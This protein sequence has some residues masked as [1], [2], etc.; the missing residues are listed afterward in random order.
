[1][2]TSRASAIAL[3]LIGIAVTIVP[4]APAQDG[5]PSAPNPVGAVVWFDLLTEDDDAVLDFYREL[6]GWEIQAHTDRHWVV[7]HNGRPIAGISQIPNEDPKAKEAFW[8]AGI[9]VDDVDT[10]FQRASARGAELHVEPADS[11]G[12]ARYAII[13][14]NDG[15]PVM[16][17]DPF[18]P[19]GGDRGPG[20]W[21]WAE[22]WSRDP[23]AAA[24]FYGDVVGFDTGTTEVGGSPY[25]VFKTRGEI[26]AGL[27]PTPHEEIQPA[28]A[29]YLL[30]ADLRAT[31]ARVEKLGGAVVARPDL[32]SSRGEVALLADPS[33]AAFFVYQRAGEG[34]S[35]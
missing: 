16:L 9:V 5:P 27:V 21:V 15:V 25:R 23:E 6:F 1:M 32:F 31:L 13:S 2:T 3:V 8:L 14:D 35:R 11:A 17:L 18:T 10:A 30:V 28:W 22:L 20:S 19:L 24:A 33:G 12:Y 29:P 7:V 4:P 26:R 34:A